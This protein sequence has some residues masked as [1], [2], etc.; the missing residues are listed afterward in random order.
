MSETQAKVEELTAPLE[1]E[2]ACGPDLTY[3][4]EFIE[5]QRSAEGTPEQISGD[6]VKPGEPPDWP[7]VEQRAVKVLGRARDLRAAVTLT[8]AWLTTEGLEGVA[9]GLE[10]VQKLT[11]TYWDG[12]HPRADEDGDLTLRF[13]SIAALI[14]ESY[15]LLPLRAVTLVSSRQLG[16]FSL[17]DWRV[18]IGKLKLTEGSEEAPPDRARI[19]GAFEEI[20][21]E[22]LHGN[23]DAAHRAQAAVAALQKTIDTNAPGMG[24]NLQPLQADLRDIARLYDDM[25]AKRSG[26]SPAEDGAEA[27]DGSGGGARGGGG[28]PGQIRTRADVVRALDAV[29]GYYRD[30]EPSSPVP[31]LVTRAKRLVNLSFME[32]VRDL[33]PSAVG[34]AT[35]FSG[36]TDDSGGGSSY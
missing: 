2:D 15:M 36:S 4:R 30:N 18:A 17:R 11:D 7:D 12:V 29:C 14:D 27:G 3:D 13:N 23:A 35:I 32:I 9:G 33:T 24:T 5:M 20:Q 19:E 28:A 10:L 25:I 34:E 21:A 1:G 26:L 8:R 6:E 31:M 16:K 22:E